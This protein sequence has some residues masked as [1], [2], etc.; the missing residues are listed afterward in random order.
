MKIFRIDDKQSSEINMLGKLKVLS[1]VS[2]LTVGTNRG[3]LWLR[4]YGKPIRI[5]KRVNRM[6]VVKSSDTQL[7]EIN[8]R[9]VTTHQGER[10]E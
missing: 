9:V 3:E 6:L 10:L 2:L 5:E 4:N 1:P 7:F 8:R